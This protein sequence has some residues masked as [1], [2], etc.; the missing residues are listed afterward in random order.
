MHRTLLPLLALALLPAC[1]DAATPP[2]GI[3][4]EARLKIVEA[5]TAGAS[6]AE[7]K[8]IPAWMLKTAPEMFKPV[9][10]NG[11]RRPDWWVNYEFSPNASYFCGS[12]GCQSVMYV[13]QAD[14]TARKVF[15]HGGGAYR[16]SGGK[17]ARK[18]Q[19]NFHGS[20]CGGYGAEECLRAWRWDNALGRYVETPNSKGQTLLPSGSIPAVYPAAKDAPAEVRAE[21]ERRLAACKAAGARDLLEESALRD[22]P[23]INGDGLRDWLV[24]SPYTDCNY[25]EGIADNDPGARLTVFASDGGAFGKAFEEKGASWNLDIA[26]PVARIG[27]VHED[28]DCGVGGKP[29]PA[30]L[31]TWDPASKALK[32]PR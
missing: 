15:E 13:T 19:I 26:G 14:G 30:H 9:D 10:I 4:E 6:E 20:A 2:A 18:L 17:S 12:G 27:I 5:V 24:G 7:I 21:V 8:E 32:L 22:I 16:F 28:A 11:D 31:L 29:C 1:A 25:A 3:V 23:D